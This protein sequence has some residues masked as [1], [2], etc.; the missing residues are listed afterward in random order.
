MSIEKKIDIL[1]EGYLRSAVKGAGIAAIPAALLA[2]YGT[3]LEQDD[4]FDRV[5]NS[6][7]A[8]VAQYGRDLENLAADNL[9][10]GDHDSLDLRGI[11]QERRLGGLAKNM[12]SAAGLAGT[13]GAGIGA[14]LHQPRPTEQAQPQPQP[15]GPIEQI[16]PQYPQL[17]QPR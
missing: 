13:L 17:P 12:G 4:Y 1:L 15:T 3:D 14:A 9:G 2:G 10:I 7:V 11:E 5:D 8:S 6:A 16:Q